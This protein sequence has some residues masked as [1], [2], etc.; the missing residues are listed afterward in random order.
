M[1]IS[2]LQ[3]TKTRFPHEL[4]SLTELCL[5]AED[6]I[7]VATVDTDDLEEAFRLTNSINSSW[8][9]NSEITLTEKGKQMVRDNGGLRST[10]VG[11]VFTINVVNF[12]VVDMFGFKEL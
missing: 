5:V 9:E 2:I 10:M 6:F 12:H 1:T 7:E 3:T 8:T 4:N 11:D